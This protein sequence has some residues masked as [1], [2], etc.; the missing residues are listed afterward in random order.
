MQD[1]AGDSEPAR[2]EDRNNNYRSIESN[3]MSLI[4]QVRTGI[5]LIESAIAREAPFGD[6]ETAAGVIVLD[7]VTPRYTNAK[8]A[9]SAC[10]ASL[11]VALHSFRDVRTSEYSPGAR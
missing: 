3:L 5:G 11:D 6:H 1:A 8:A 4:D 9:L 10:N 2:P 7:D